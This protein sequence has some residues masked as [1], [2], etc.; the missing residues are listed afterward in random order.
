M[1]RSKVREKLFQYLFQL[2][3]Q[4]ENRAEQEEKHLELLKEE[5]FGEE[6]CAYFQELCQKYYEEAQSIDEE[7]S[8]YLRA[9]TLERLAKVDLAL[10]RL[11][12]LE[13]RH[14]GQTP[15]AVIASEI[16][17]LSKRYADVSSKRYI[18]GILGR[19]IEDRYSES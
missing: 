18:N 16:V 3:V 8:G 6:D 5:A 12:V 17:I 14:R 2:E 9:W 10:L 19:L 15:S 11:A 7:I 1:K 4:K 13:L